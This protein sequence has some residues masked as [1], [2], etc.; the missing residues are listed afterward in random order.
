[1]SVTIVGTLAID[2][3]KTPH[4][5]HDSILGGSAAYAGTAASIFSDV[6]IVSIVGNDYPSEFVSYLK[7][8]NINLEGVE[9]AQGKTFCWKGS[10][11]GDMGHANTI[12]T[13]LN[14]LEDFNPIIPEKIKNTE[15]AFL[16]NVDPILQKKAIQQFTNPKLV[17][18]DSM[19]FWIEHKLDDLKETIKIVDI[20]IIN[21]QEIR[22]LTGISNIVAA[23]Q[24]V[25]KMGPKRIVVKKGENGSVMYNGKDYFFCPAVPLEKV[26]DTTGAGDSFAGAFSGYLSGVD[27]LSEEAFKKAVIVGTLVSSFT[28]QDFSVDSLKTVNK[29]MLEE[30]Y[31]IWKKYVSMPDAIGIS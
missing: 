23:M 17:I 7:G 1:M 13:G 20:L 15:I 18:L 25:L 22:Q 9:F 3:V 8:K 21:D 5:E 4:G 28:V 26:I 30:K 14:V 31:D 29:Q 19:N 27:E 12:Y 11:E 24:A 6:N 2:S 16:A 10:Y